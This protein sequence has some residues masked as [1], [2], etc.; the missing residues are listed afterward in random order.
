MTISCKRKKMWCGFAV[1]ILLFMV[2]SCSSPEIEEESE[3]PIKIYMDEYKASVKRYANAVSHAY[4]IFYHET[5][6]SETE[7]DLLRSEG[8]LPRCRKEPYDG[9]QLQEYYRSAKW[10]FWGERYTI[11]VKFL[12]D[13]GLYG[14]FTAETR[15]EALNL[16]YEDEI[17]FSVRTEED[18]QTAL[19]LVLPF[20]GKERSIFALTQI[21]TQT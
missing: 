8:K 15:D 12:K 7:F 14:L 13:K 19:L 18:F 1:L 9:I 3:D 20:Q 21:P 2:V 5:G 17:F 4:E 16:L 6:L 10:G 11:M